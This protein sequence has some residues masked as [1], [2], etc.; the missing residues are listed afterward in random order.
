MGFQEIYLG[1]K[2]FAPCVR[3][4]ET[5]FGRV[6]SP[7][8]VGEPEARANESVHAS[9]IS[10]DVQ[11]DNFQRDISSSSSPA[12]LRVYARYWCA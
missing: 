7:V 4:R 3:R 6:E 1:A 10:V 5:M 11:I 9:D 8:L 2:L 12:V